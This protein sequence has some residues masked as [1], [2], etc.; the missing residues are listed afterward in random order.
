MNINGHYIK[1]RENIDLANSHELNAPICYIDMVETVIRDFQTATGTKVNEFIYSAYELGEPL[2][3][4]GC[5]P[6]S[7]CDHPKEVH[8]PFVVCES[9]CGCRLEYDLE[10]FYIAYLDGSQ[11]NDLINCDELQWLFNTDKPEFIGELKASVERTVDMWVK[12]NQRY[13]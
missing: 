6:F 7:V 4:C 5:E 11:T 9:T 3:D 8:V 2:P 12:I 13:D 10:R 1:G